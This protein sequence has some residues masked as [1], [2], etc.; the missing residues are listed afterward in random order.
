MWLLGV[1]AKA[2]WFDLRLPSCGPGFQSHAHHLRF[3]KMWQLSEKCT[4]GKSRWKLHWQLYHH[5]PLLLPPY[6]EL[7]RCNKG[8]WR[9]EGRCLA[10]RAKRQEIVSLLCEIKSSTLL[11]CFA[12]NWQMRL[13]L[14]FFTQ[15]VELDQVL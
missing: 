3:K 11:S 14:I 10:E 4:S 15:K 7:C 12:R 5:W 6:Y 1:A 8:H 9:T 13:D 2:T